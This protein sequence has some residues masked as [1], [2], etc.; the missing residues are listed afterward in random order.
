MP[1]TAATT[2]AGGPRL[3]A[4][5]VEMVQ[6]IA[7]GRRIAAIAMELGLTPGAVR[8]T[9]RRL[10]SRFGGGRREAVLDSL[11]RSGHLRAPAATSPVPSSALDAGQEGLLTQLAAGWTSRQISADLDISRRTT[12]D[13]IQALLMRL[14]ARTRAH[15]VRRGWELGYLSAA[16]VLPIAPEPPGV[17][18]LVRLIPPPAH[19][20][21]GI[22]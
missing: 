1:D 17:T 12:G 9:I 19:P 7:D 21:I 14:G 18:R 5:E 8:S 15:A 10:H 13:R 2:Q 11:Y 4:R 6:L 22:L 16:T 20:R 3:S